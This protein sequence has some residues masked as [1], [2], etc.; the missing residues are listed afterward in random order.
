MFWGD[1]ENGE[2]RNSQSPPLHKSNNDKT[3]KLAETK[4]LNFRN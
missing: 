3:E 1:S 2:I 4:P